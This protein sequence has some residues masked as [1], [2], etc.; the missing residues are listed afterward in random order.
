MQYKKITYRYMIRL[1]FVLFI[2]TGCQETAAEASAGGTALRDVRIGYYTLTNVQDPAWNK[3]MYDSVYQGYGYEYMLAVGQYAGWR[4]QFVHVGYDEG[5]LM[6]QEGKLDIMC[7]VE[8][9]PRLE[10]LFSFVTADAR[11]RYQ[12]SEYYAVRKENTVLLQELIAAMDELQIAD[13]AFGA[14]L[15]E[16]YYGRGR[17]TVLILTPAEKDYILQHPVARVAYDPLWYPIS[18]RDQ[19]GQFAGAMAKIYEKI[20]ERTGL[21]FEFEPSA[22]FSEALSIFEGG[23]AELLA[24]LPYDFLWADRHKAS[25]TLPCQYISIVG[26]FKPENMRMHT[27]AIPPDYYQQYLSETIRGDNYEFHNYPTAEACLDAVLNGEVDCALLNSYQM[28]YYRKLHK[29][30]GMSFR[31]MPALGYRLSTAVSRQADPRLRSIITKALE[32]M[33]TS[34]MDQIFRE[35]AQVRQRTNYSDMFYAN[36]WLLATGVM[37]LFSLTSCVVLYRQNR[38]MLTLLKKR[39]GEK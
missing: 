22:N 36:V 6:L 4:C 32:G 34:E 8:R 23:D 15:Y 2:L 18:Y 21:Q 37:L 17:G 14:E 38:R 33:G 13:P 16:K 20:A 30:N 25:L 27:V 3:V 7:K 29:Y 10:G 19:S 28:E 11:R 1:L 12:A 31:V 9:T 35:A 5:L 39:R 26:A 24:E